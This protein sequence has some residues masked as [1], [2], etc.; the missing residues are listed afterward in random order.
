MQ[1]LV[2]ADR[3]HENGHSTAPETVSLGSFYPEIT[4]SQ[5]RDQM[6]IDSN[7]SD[8]RLYH[9]AAEAALLVAG[10]LAAFQTA[11]LQRGCTTLAQAASEMPHLNGKTAAEYRFARA[12]MSYTKALLLEK[13]ADTDATGK[14][15]TRFEAKQEQAEDHRRNG[16]FAIADLL[17]R[18]RCDAELI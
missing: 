1:G 15:G 2:F 5:I 17:G 3:P 8:G 10:Q 7:I 4:L 14:T 11:A 13:Y 16:H 12:V 18:R 9:S 6:R